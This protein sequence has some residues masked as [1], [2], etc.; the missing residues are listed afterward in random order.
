MVFLQRYV[1]LTGLQRW[2]WTDTVFFEHNLVLT[3]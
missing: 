3:I 1:V 2:H